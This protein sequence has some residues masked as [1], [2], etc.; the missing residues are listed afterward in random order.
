MDDTVHDFIYEASGRIKVNHN[1]PE[2]E[3]A[4]AQSLYDAVGLGRDPFSQETI[5]EAD[6][7]WSHRY[8]T[9]K[10]ATDMLQ[11]MKTASNQQKTSS[12][13]Q[14]FLTLRRDAL[15]GTR[16]DVFTEE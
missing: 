14:K 7:R 10:I 6:Y 15:P 13:M 16:K 5:S 1:L 2:E 8:E 11:I 12:A 9:W 3:R 4:K